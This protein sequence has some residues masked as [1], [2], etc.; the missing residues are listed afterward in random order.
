MPRTIK[1]KQFVIELS[2]RSIRQNKKQPIDVP[3]NPSPIPFDKD[4]LHIHEL[5]YG[6]GAFAAEQWP[7]L[8]HLKKYKGMSYLEY[9]DVAVRN[10]LKVLGKPASDDEFESGFM[11][12]FED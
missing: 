6:L 12:G 11:I 4:I 10:C 3:G 9:R 8:L 5:G 7:A 1:P 2:V